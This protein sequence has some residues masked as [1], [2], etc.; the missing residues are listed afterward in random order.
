MRLP[1]PSTSKM[2]Q[3]GWLGKTPKKAHMF[4]NYGSD[5]LS[6]NIPFDVET[7]SPWASSAHSLY[8]ITSKKFMDRLKDT[9]ADIYFL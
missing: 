2:H 7:L 5:Y 3:K 1:R 8:K 9:R 6:T 4:W